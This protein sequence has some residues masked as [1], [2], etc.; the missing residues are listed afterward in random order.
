MYK[1]ADGRKFVG[2]YIAD[3]KEGHGE[4]YFND[5]TKY[6]GNFQNNMKHD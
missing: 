5:G 1:W 3:E 4:I 2:K 6:E